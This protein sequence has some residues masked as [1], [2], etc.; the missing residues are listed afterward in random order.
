MKIETWPHKLSHLIVLIL[1]MITFGFFASSL[2]KELGWDLASYH[3][4]NPYAWLH[5]RR[6]WDYWPPSQLQAYF[7]PTLDFLTYFLINQ[8]SPRATTFL[9]GA[10]QGV[11][12]WLLYCL[13]Y[14]L[15]KRD[16]GRGI[17]WAAMSAAFVGYLGPVTFSEM[18]SFQGDLIISIF[19]LSAVL[20]W[21]MALECLANKKWMILSGLML[22]IGAG[23]KLTAILF[24]LGFLPTFLLLGADY[25]KNLKWFVGWF[26]AVLTGFLVSDGYWMLILWR[27]HANPFFPFFNAVFHSPDF[28]TIN[29]RDTRF[30]PHGFFNTLFYPFYFSW[31]S[32]TSELPFVDFRFAIV[33]LLLILNAVIGSMQKIVKGVKANYSR[34]FILFTVFYLSSYLVWQIY[35]SNVRYLVALEMLSPLMIILLIHQIIKNASI[36]LVMV[37]LIF[38]F[39]IYTVKPLLMIDRLPKF[40]DNYFGVK[41]PKFITNVEQALVLTAYSDYVLTTLPKPQ[42][43]LIPFFPAQWRFVGV[44]FQFDQY[45]LPGAVKGL[46]QSFQGDVYLLTTR[47]TLP[48]LYR[49]AHELGYEKYN[50]CEKILSDRQKLPHL[51]DDDVFI[52]PVK[53]IS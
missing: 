13:S 21:A 40:G 31:N 44:P 51:K 8:F 42:N 28:M 18:G 35:F 48:A 36:R 46:A 17:F 37:A 2:G 29:W 19:V 49:A 7:N 6:H 43:Y 47:A 3:Y 5:H 16:F 38:I 10:I 41:L 1:A 39:L 25:K 24:V 27:E 4:Y 53:K 12:F 22:G 33:Y 23:L 45:S 32:Q 26:A 9:L 20:M 11:N 14:L 34:Q 50:Q 30:F 52:C 15:L